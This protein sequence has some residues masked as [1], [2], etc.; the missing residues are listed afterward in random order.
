MLVRKIWNCEFNILFVDIMFCMVR[1]TLGNSTSWHVRHALSVL[2]S[3]LE[4][5]LWGTA[6]PFSADSDACW[7]ICR[8]SLPQHVTMETD[9]AG[10]EWGEGRCWRMLC[11]WCRCVFSLSRALCV[12]RCLSLIVTARWCVPSPRSAAMQHSAASQRIKRQ[13][14]HWRMG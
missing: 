6:R 4:T 12:S 10:R 2:E 3:L 5:G 11:H 13:N 1:L 14:W 9:G 7:E 8:A